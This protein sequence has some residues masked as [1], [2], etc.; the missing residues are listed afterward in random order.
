MTSLIWDFEQNFKDFE[1]TSF[2]LIAVLRICTQNKYINHKCTATLQVHYSILSLLDKF[3]NVVILVN[4][5]D[6]TVLKVVPDL[7]F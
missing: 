5:K 1:F 4:Q 7:C 3:N 6:F 2:Y